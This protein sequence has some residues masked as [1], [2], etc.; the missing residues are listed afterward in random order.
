MSDLY[1]GIFPKCVAKGQACVFN[2]NDL[3]HIKEVRYQCCD[4]TPK[5][6]QT[7][8]IDRADEGASVEFTKE[9]YQSLEFRVR[10][11]E[12]M[13]DKLTKHSHSVARQETDEVII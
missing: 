5:H 12:K 10:S 8:M 3:D 4:K 1:C 13:V 9:D 2:R 11:L 6:I 7:H